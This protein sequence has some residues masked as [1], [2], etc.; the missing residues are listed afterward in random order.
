MAELERLTE[1]VG[2]ACWPAF[3]SSGLL[4]LL[5]VTGELRPN[6]DPTLET[7]VSFAAAAEDEEL[8]VSGLL[9]LVE[10]RREPLVVELVFMSS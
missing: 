9:L 6:G 3:S 1:N 4:L 2:S 5:P 7:P 8:T 10:L